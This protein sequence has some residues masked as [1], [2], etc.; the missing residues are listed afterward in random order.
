MLACSQVF[1]ALRD[2]F[3]LGLG[4]LARPVSVEHGVHAAK[5]VRSVL[6]VFLLQVMVDLWKHVSV[7]LARANRRE[8]V[9]GRMMSKLSSEPPDGEHHSKEVGYHDG[10]CLLGGLEPH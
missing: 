2:E 7:L 1:L 3:V 10:D 6:A 5:L 8:D 4:L 9:S